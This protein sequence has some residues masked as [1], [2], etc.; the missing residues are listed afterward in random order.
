MSTASTDTKFL[1]ASIKHTT[2]F[3]EHIQWWA[4]DSRGYTVCIE[5]AGLYDEAEARGICC[6]T[7]SYIAVPMS[8]A[9]PLSRSTPYYRRGNG[10]LDKLYDGEKHRVVPNSKWS[11]KEL[12]LGRLQV[13]YYLSPTPI[14]S[15]KSRAIYLT[16]EGGAS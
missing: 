3:T 16:D 10:T 5:K 1:I 13:G 9:E 2:K 14:S 6:V 8:V 12:L 15:K 7:G 4:P 11:W